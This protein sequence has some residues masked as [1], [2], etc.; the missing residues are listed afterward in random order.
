[1]RRSSATALISLTLAVVEPPAI[2][3]ARIGVGGTTSQHPEAPLARQYR[4]VVLRYL[5]HFG[6]IW[7]WVLVFFDGH[8]YAEVTY[9]VGLS[10]VSGLSKVVS[11]PVSWRL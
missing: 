11:E 8:D 6:I 7:P 9:G 4:F 2:H 3:P 1:M 10:V 5:F